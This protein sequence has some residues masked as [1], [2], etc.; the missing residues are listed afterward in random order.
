MS[1]EANKAI[2]ARI[3]EEVYSQG[4]VSVVDEVMDERYLN[5]DLLPGEE[6]GAEGVKQFALSL[7]GAFPDLRFNVEEMLAKDDLVVTRWL[8][9]GTHEGEFLAVPASGRR[10]AATGMTM[11]RLENGRIVE[12]WTNWDALSMLTQIGVLPPPKGG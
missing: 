1:T 9:T 6:P 3:W 2:V 12:G 5:H 8:A 10:M 4:D 7:R 11:H